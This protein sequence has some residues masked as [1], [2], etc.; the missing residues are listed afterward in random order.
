[1]STPIRLAVA[2]IAASTLLLAACTDDDG[3][4]VRTL[5]DCGSASAPASGS[6]TA[7]QGSGSSTEDCP[8][9]SGS[10]SGVAP[11][12]VPVGDIATAATTVEVSLDEWTVVPSVRTAPRGRVGF[13]VR[14]EGKEAH[15]LV[16]VKGVEP[17][18]LP[19]DRNG[20]LDES[21]LPDGALIGE[22]EGFPAGDS[23]EGVFDLSPGSY[24]LVCN[25]TETEPNGEKESHLHEGMVTTFEVT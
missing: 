21:G 18:A 10:G 6:G 8:S 4:S 12:C 19:L 20:A 1:M 2:V 23:C 25:I 5:A 13:A 15:E 16:I 24:T 17:N 7:E 9:G 11:E 3:A 14:N 22:I